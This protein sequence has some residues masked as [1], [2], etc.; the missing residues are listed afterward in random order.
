MQV[1]LWDGSTRHVICKSLTLFS[2]RNYG[3]VIHEF[4]PW[5]HFRA[6]KYNTITANY[7]NHRQ[8]L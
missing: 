1:W 6:T 8:L 3:R 5:F 7:Y 2:F 4:D